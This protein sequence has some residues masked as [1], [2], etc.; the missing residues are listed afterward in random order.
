MQV[1]AEVFH[2]PIYKLALIGQMLLFLPVVGS[3][4]VYF[5]LDGNQWKKWCSIDGPKIQ[6][7][8]V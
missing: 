1:S 8:K 6:T 3:W 4:V 7:E 5:G 2:I